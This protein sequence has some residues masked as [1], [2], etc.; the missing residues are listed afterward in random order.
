MTPP[1]GACGSK[2]NKATSTSSPIRPKPPQNPPAPSSA[3]ETSAARRAVA[4]A[5]LDAYTAQAG[6]SGDA[7]SDIC[8]LI[9]D[10]M[11]LAA[12]KKPN[13]DP[14]RLVE[15]A[16]SHFAAEAA[17]DISM[18]VRTSLTVAVRKRATAAADYRPTWS[19]IH[20][21]KPPKTRSL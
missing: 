19:V 5:A 14:Y 11:L 10:L 9:S 18:P 16:S 4:S 8:D 1:A 21:R 6:S 3:D 15:L 12:S 7:V 17:G 13:T 2:P 20:P